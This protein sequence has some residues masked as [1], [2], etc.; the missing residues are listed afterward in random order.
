M[1]DQEISTVKATKSAK[2]S[3]K[4]TGFIALNGY[5]DDKNK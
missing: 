2:K 3:T 4:S 5:R 1:Y